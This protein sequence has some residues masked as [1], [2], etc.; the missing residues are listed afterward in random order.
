M[1][2][3][4]RLSY[5]RLPYKSEFMGVIVGMLLGDGSICKKY[6]HKLTLCQGEKQKDYLDLKCEILKSFG[7]KMFAVRTNINGFGDG[8]N[9]KK[10]KKFIVDFGDKRN[11][12]FYRKFYGG[13]KRKITYQFIR[14]LNQYGLAIW[15]MDDGN[16]QMSKKKSKKHP[17]GVRQN[18]Y[19]LNTQGYSYEENVMLQEML[20]K[21]FGLISNIHKD[22]K[23]FKLYF[24]AKGNGAKTLANLVRPYIHPMF[25]YKLDYKDTLNAVKS[26]DI[27]QSQ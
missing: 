18:Y 24:G 1:E 3:S 19:C 4:Q 25:N 2:N 22:K 21:K 12:W 16:N 15:F 14:H 6:T 26:E 20:E 13:G 5:P 10:Y 23:Y 9:G 27:V 8:S 17:E 11:E 7:Y